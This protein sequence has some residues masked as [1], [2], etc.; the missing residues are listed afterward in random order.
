MKWT[1]ISQFGGIKPLRFVITGC[2]KRELIKKLQN[3][4]NIT[5]STTQK[6]KCIVRI[7]IGNCTLEFRVTAF[8]SK[9]VLFFLT[10]SFFSIFLNVLLELW[11]HKHFPGNAL[12]HLKHHSKPGDLIR[13]KRHCLCLMILFSS[14]RFGF[15]IE[16]LD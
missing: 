5:F 3:P 2:K 14:V 8:P 6:W 16:F 10:N 12:L 11:S 9:F 7:S 1:F 15:D 13:V 4:T